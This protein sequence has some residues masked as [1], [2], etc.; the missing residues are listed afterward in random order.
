MRKS[1]LRNLSLSDQL[2]ILSIDRRTSWQDMEDPRVHHARVL[3]YYL[4]VRPR[5]HMEERAMLRRM[6]KGPGRNAR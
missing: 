5:Q 3:W 6:P 2:F 4:N 1:S